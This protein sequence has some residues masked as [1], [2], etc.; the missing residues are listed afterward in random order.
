MD[1]GTEV[2]VISDKSLDSLS[3][4]ELQSSTKRLC[5][6]DRRLLAVMGEF[7]ASMSYKDRSCI[8]TVHNFKKLQQNLLGLPAIWAL[9]KWMLFR[10]LTNTPASSQALAH[11]LTGRRSIE[12]CRS[13]IKKYQYAYSNHKVIN[14]VRSHLQEE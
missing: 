6:P 8:Q 2:T 13:T 14:L 10:G 1:T 11:F 7:P 3:V 12:A 5:G 4:I 9:N